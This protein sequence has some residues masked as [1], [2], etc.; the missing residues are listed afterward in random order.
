LI[1]AEVGGS[2][3]RALI[4]GVRVGVVIVEDAVVVYSPVA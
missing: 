1:R 3:T 2:S 4:N